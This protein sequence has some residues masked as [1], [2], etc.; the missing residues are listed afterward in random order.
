MSRAERERRISTRLHH[1]APPNMSSTDMRDGGGPRLTAS[2][3]QQNLGGGIPHP[4]ARNSALR[5]PSAA[6]DDPTQ[7]RS[8]SSRLVKKWGLAWLSVIIACTVCH[9]FV[10][11][12]HYLGTLAVPWAT[13][14]AFQYMTVKGGPS[15]P[16][17]SAV[18]VCVWVYIYIWLE[19]YRSARGFA[20][21]LSCSV[22]PAFVVFGVRCM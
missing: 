5:R 20:I 17:L 14:C 10:S 3:M 11:L 13:N 18:S 15:S 9:L 2:A 12:L 4:G 1:G 19:M 16:T 7:M 21:S 8:T 6:K 22:W